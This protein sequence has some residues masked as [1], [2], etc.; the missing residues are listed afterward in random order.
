MI[1]RAHGACQSRLESSGGESDD[2]PQA[3]VEEE[4]NA[5][6]SGVICRKCNNEFMSDSRFCRNCGAA[7]EVPQDPQH[8][9]L[10]FAL[11]AMFVYFAWA[12]AFYRVDTKHATRASC[13]V[14]FDVTQSH[15][16]E[17]AGNRVTAVPLC[18]IVMS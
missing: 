11:C 17:N 3:K 13:L 5:V 7:R 10:I 6:K 2:D 18:S 4:A 1:A 14:Q 12:L 15:T 9:S 8:A 16:S